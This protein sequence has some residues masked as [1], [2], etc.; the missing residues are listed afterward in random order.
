MNQEQKEIREAVAAGEKALF[1][2]YA[3]RDNLHSARNWGIFDL[4]GGGMLVNMM[5]H[6]RISKASAMLE[7]AKRNLLIF[8]RE[9]KDVAVPMDIRVEIGSFLSFA[10]F[11]FDGLVADYLVQSK[12]ADAREQVEDAIMQVER[13][14]ADLRNL[15]D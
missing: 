10:D 4:L 11:F 2:L 7:D 15:Q 1:S 5:K 8:Q 3:A 6:S 13:L 12:I 9:L 14:V